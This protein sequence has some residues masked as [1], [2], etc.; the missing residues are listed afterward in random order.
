LVDKFDLSQTHSSRLIYLKTV[1]LFLL[2]KDYDMAAQLL[3][4]L[5]PMTNNINMELADFALILEAIYYI[6]RQEWAFL[7][8]WTEALQK[9][10]QR[11][12]IKKPILRL[13]IQ[14]A[15]KLSNSTSAQHQQMFKK[16]LSQLDKLNPYQ[17]QDY[18]AILQI[19]RYQEWLEAKSKNIA[20]QQYLS[21]K[22]QVLS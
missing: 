8:S 18:L 1:E 17:A 9:R 16:H 5:Q 20:W 22:I 3:E 7:Q 2:R 6:E 15:Q 21:E 14:L 10:M 13:I 11:Q 4:V 19:F 12:K